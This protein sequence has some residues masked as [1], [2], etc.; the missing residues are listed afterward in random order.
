MS[1]GLI[2]ELNAALEQRGGQRLSRRCRVVDST[3]SHPA[4]FFVASEALCDG[5]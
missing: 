1:R 3:L 5:R 4:Q 2:A